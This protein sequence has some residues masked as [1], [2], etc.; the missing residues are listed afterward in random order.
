MAEGLKFP[1]PTPPNVPILQRADEITRLVDIFNQIKPKNILEIGSFCG[2]TL[3]Y[4]LYFAPKQATVVSVDI[5]VLDAQKMM[6][7]KARAQ[8]DLWAREDINF[9]SM[10][11]DSTS[12]HFLPRLDTLFP[13]GIDFAFVD[14]GHAY[15]VIESDVNSILPRMNKGGALTLHDIHT[16]PVNGIEVRKFWMDLVSNMPNGIESVEEIGESDD[17]KG[18]IGSGIGVLYI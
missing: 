2:G 17:M 7:Y 5:P 13:D 12:V 4:W 14:G 11:L 9:Q 8:W 6:Q 15:Q 10:L 16:P 18:G 3:W 1:K